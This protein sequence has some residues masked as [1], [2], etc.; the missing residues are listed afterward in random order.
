MKWYRPPSLVPVGKLHCKLT[1]I[2][3]SQSVPTRFRAMRNS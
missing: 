1:F 3:S 2:I